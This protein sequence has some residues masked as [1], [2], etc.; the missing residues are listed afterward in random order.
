MNGYTEEILEDMASPD[1]RYNISLSVSV[2]DFQA[3]LDN[4]GEYIVKEIAI[5]DEFQHYTHLFFKSPFD[6][7]QLDHRYYRQAVWLEN[8]LHRI[9]WEY[10]DVELSDDVLSTLLRNYDV[11]YVKGLEKANYLSKFHRLIKRIPDYVEKPRLLFNT[12]S[13]VYENVTCSVHTDINFGGSCALN[14]AI[15]FMEWL[16]ERTDYTRESDRLHSLQLSSQ[17]TTDEE[18]KRLAKAGFYY[19]RRADNVICAWCKYSYEWHIA[20]VKYYVQ[21]IPI[22]FEVIVPRK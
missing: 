18:R 16:K 15:A 12:G 9:K 21:N 7:S 8:N 6:K 22:E 14:T 2:V 1:S 10:G 3:F 13:G 11:V 19:D 5:V 20:C 4:D 17:V